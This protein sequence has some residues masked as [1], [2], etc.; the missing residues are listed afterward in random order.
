MTRGEHRLDALLALQLG[1]GHERYVAWL[2]T[3]GFGG[4]GDPGQNGG[5]LLGGVGGGSCVHEVQ[6]RTSETGA[7]AQP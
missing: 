1:N 5:A 3:D 4:D 2:A 6:A 7:P